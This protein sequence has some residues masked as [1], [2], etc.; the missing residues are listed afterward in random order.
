MRIRLSTGDDYNLA[1]CPHQFVGRCDDCSSSAG[2]R[3]S[4][5]M[6][7]DEGGTTFSPE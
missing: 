4:D 3:E 7:T 5:Q 2:L 6:V 1:T